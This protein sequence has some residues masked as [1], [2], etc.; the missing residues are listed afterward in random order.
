MS[1]RCPHGNTEEDGCERCYDDAMFVREHKLMRRT[2]REIAKRT[3]NPMTY[4]LASDALDEV[5]RTRGLEPEE[6]RE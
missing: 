6:V 4:K 2:L 3:Q 1:V 5:D